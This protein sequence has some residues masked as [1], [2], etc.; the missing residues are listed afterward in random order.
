MFQPNTHQHTHTHTRL[1][2]HQH[3]FTPLYHTFSHT[4]PAS[5]AT[6]HYGRYFF[7]HR[8]Y[9]SVHALVK[10]T[11]K[12]TRRAQSLRCPHFSTT[13]S[14]WAQES[15]VWEQQLFQTVRPFFFC[16][17]QQ[18][19]EH[20]STPPRKKTLKTV[21]IRCQTCPLI[22]E[23][24]LM[25]Q[26][27]LIKKERKKC[28]AG[29]A[30]MKP[31]SGPLRDSDWTRTYLSFISHF[32]SLFFCFTLITIQNWDC[33][34]RMMRGSCPAELKKKKKKKK[35]AKKARRKHSI[36]ISLTSWEGVLTFINLPLS[37]SSSPPF[38]VN[39][40]VFTHAVN[41]KE[42]DTWEAFSNSPRERDTGIL[43]RLYHFWYHN[44][45]TWRSHTVE[46]DTV[47]S[48]LVIKR[49]LYKYCTLYSYLTDCQDFC[50]V[51]MPLLFCCH[52]QQHPWHGGGC[53]NSSSA[54]V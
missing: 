34:D 14:G 12:P 41:K 32:V 5:E 40:F 22:D 23:I 47:T 13:S 27:G 3:Q 29:W 10:L 26:A 38:P 50:K 48:F 19:E 33:G 9:W 24:Y 4:L 39:V 15:A 53:K 30:V 25:C 20:P 2:T 16:Y 7:S 21:F 17:L 11:S 35:K 1:L 8:W 44:S 54:N 49:V 18:M 42:W 51:V 6:A 37:S 28:W 31:L 43:A 46:S 36:S 45:Q 52:P